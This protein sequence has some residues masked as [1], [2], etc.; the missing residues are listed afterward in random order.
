MIVEIKR[1]HVIHFECVVIIGIL[2]CMGFKPATFVYGW[3]DINV[4][5]ADVGVG[6]VLHVVSL[7]V[8]V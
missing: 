5:V 3:Y 4:V 7:A 8:T 6:G 1:W 2:I